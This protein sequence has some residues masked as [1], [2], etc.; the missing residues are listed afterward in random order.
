MT[1]L[2][3]VTGAEE[4]VRRLWSPRSVAVVGASSRPGALSWWPLELLRRYGF[5]GP[6]HA[7]NPRRDRIGDVPCVPSISEV[8]GPVDLAVVPLAAADTVV[9]VKECAAAGVRTVVLPS[10][11]FGELGE[12]GRA[13]ER[14]LL[15]AARETGMRIVGPNTDGVANL[16]LGALASIQPLFGQGVRPGRVAVVTQS[17]ATAASLLVRLDA[18]GIGCRLYASAGN[19]IDLG[20]ADYL[21]VAVQDPEVGVVVS[22]VEAIRRPRDFVAVAELAA[23]LGKPIVL[24]KVGRTEQAAARAAAHTGALAGPD[25]IYDALFRSL[26]VIRVGELSEIVA[27]VKLHLG[28]GVPDSA[29]LGV[30]SVSGGQAGAI[31]DRAPEFGIRVPVL[32]EPAQERLAEL[33]PFGSPLNPCDLTGEV[34]VRHDLAAGVYR[35]YDADPGI[36]LVIYARKELTGDAGRHAA[37]ALV[38]ARAEGATPLVV[39]AM[40]GQFNEDETATYAGAGVPAFTSLSELLTAYGALVRHG[41]ALRARAG[42]AVASAGPRGVLPVGSGTVDEDA[43]RTL[44]AEYGLRGPAAETVPDVESAVAAAERIGYPVAVKVVSRRIAHKTEAGGVR[45]GLTGAGE[46][47]RAGNEILAA[48][49]RHLGGDPADGLLVQ[50]QI[51][52][53]V[54]IIAGL[55]ADPQ[56]GPFVLLGTGGITAELLADSVLKP[57]PVTA[58]EAREMVG[59]IRGNALLRGFRGAPPADVDALVEA[60]VALS[61]LGADHADRI[62]ELDLNPLLVR[63]E[64]LGVVAVDALIVTKESS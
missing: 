26:G 10:Q 46:V 17:G 11:G 7:V 30:M 49:R 28:V 43:A 36:G 16:A 8:D 38:A 32:G 63:P 3:R 51:V 55:V 22:F 41:A 59:E 18:E 58:G 6:V 34:A 37:R 31:A 13:A 9:A 25:R 20:L 56:F 61:H 52:D 62:A 57:A 15:A 24:I 45:L 48:A 1:E 54:E 39:Y 29:G 21:S 47:R 64:G 27:V 40:D 4:D 35:A 14:E 60:I 44:L 53:G 50:H 42:R 5:R 33:L 19:E 23:R 12:E 2:I